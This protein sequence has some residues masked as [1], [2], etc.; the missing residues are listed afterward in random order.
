MASSPTQA[1]GSSSTLIL[2]EGSPI[3]DETTFAIVDVEPSTQSVDFVIQRQL[4]WSVLSPATLL[5]N[6]DDLKIGWC[7]VHSI[8]VG[9]IVL[10]KDRDVDITKI[11][12][13]LG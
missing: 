10:Q 12:R 7:A 2:F 3:I 13:N 8:I 4:A 1:R 5:A 11:S 9:A 6:M